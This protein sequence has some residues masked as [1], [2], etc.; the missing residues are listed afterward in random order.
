MTASPDPGRRRRR[1]ALLA[2]VA[3]V[4][5]L[6]LASTG[7]QESAPV[8]PADRTLRIAVVP[9]GTNMTFWRTV[10]AGAIS[11]DDLDQRIRDELLTS[12]ED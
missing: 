3:G 8:D 2:M 11:A 10:H 6:G 7:C 5:T 12:I 4:L 9:K 1:R